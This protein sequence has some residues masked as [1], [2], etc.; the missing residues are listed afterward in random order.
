MSINDLRCDVC[1]CLIGMPEGGIRFAYHAGKPLLRDASG[2]MCGPCWADVA[3]TVNPLASRQ[4]ADCGWALTRYR[5]LHVRCLDG[6]QKWRLCAE[7][8]VEFLNRLRTV[9]PKIDLATFRF[10]F[11]HLEEDPDP[12]TNGP[13]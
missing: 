10:P 9:D 2:L 4:C 12:E 5:S 11:A 1:G 3:G 7:H 6:P 13:G 8:A